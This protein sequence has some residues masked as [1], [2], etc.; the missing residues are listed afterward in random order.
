VTPAGDPPVPG[1]GAVHRPSRERGSPLP[2]GCFGPACRGHPRGRAG[3]GVQAHQAASERW[4]HVSSRTG[5]QGPGRRQGREASAHRA[6]RGREPSSFY[7]RSAPWRVWTFTLFLAV[8]T[9]S[10]GYVWWLAPPA[11]LMPVARRRSSATGR[12]RGR[13][14]PAGPTLVRRPWSAATGRPTLVRQDP[15]ARWPARIG[16]L[17]CPVGPPCLAARISDS[18]ATSGILPRWPMPRA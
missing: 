15:Y 5:R 18:P 2:S 14:T 6:G 16:P 10:F 4:H 9:V 8:A 11:Q 1:P 13:P 7:S 12:S 3:D 17:A